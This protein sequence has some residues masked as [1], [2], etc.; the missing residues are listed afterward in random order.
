MVSCRCL[1]CFCRC[2]FLLHL[3][4][5]LYTLND[6]VKLP[7]AVGPTLDKL[8]FSSCLKTEFHYWWNECFTSSYGLQRNLPTRCEMSCPGMQLHQ[9]RAELQLHVT[10]K[11][12]FDQ[13]LPIRPNRQ[14][15]SNWTEAKTSDAQNSDRVTLGAGRW[16]ARRA[17]LTQLNV[18]VCPAESSELE[19]WKS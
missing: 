6:E 14:P 4:Y 19:L 11:L 13:Q 5:V 2:V 9:S 1:L 18:Y 15:T 16:L 8:A 12:D 10:A 7:A 3:G 17:K